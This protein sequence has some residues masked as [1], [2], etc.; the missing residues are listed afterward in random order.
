MFISFQVFLLPKMPVHNF[1]FSVGVDLQT[2]IAYDT[3]F[4]ILK[5]CRCLLPLES[6]ST[7]ESSVPFALYVHL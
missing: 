6:V 7:F 2:Y 4:V 3:S 5:Y 1:C